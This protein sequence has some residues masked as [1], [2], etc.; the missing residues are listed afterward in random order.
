ML[1]LKIC[2]TVLLALAAISSFLKNI[3]IFDDDKAV[4]LATIVDWSTIALVIFVVWR[5]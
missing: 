2:A 3:G 5:Y 1:A 4:I